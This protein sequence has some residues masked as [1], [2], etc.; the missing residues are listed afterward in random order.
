LLGS[1]A[2]SVSRQARPSPKPVFSTSTTAATR[3]LKLYLDSSQTI[4]TVSSYHCEALDIH[5]CSIL[6]SCSLFEN[7][8]HW[9]I[10]LEAPGGA[11]CAD[12]PPHGFEVPQGSSDTWNEAAQ[13]HNNVKSRDEASDMDHSDDAQ[14]KTH[15][16][17]D[18]H[19]GI[20]T[21]EGG[22]CYVEPGHWC[23]K[24]SSCYD[25]CAC[26]K[27][28][29]KR[30]IDTTRSTE[31]ASEVRTPSE[32]ESIV[33]AQVLDSPYGTCSKQVWGHSSCRDNNSVIVICDPADSNWRAIGKCAGGDFCCESRRDNP[34]AAE[35]KC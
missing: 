15:Q 31:R 12:A 32:S 3:K 23:A 2:S 26:C 29:K 27:K 13:G 5:Q 8:V 1:C 34:N 17:T 9:C 11:V 10:D 19:R 25:D 33:A 24:G 35:C 6:G 16:C 30:G 14:G 18:T 7:C 22:F 4:I 20:L 28:D 21:C